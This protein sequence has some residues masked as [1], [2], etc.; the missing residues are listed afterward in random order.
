M[1]SPYPLEEISPG[2]CVHWA[3]PVTCHGFF[4][5][6]SLLLE[7]FIANLFS[8]F[9][10]FIYK[11]VRLLL[12]LL[13]IFILI[14]FLASRA[15]FDFQKIYP[16]IFQIGVVFNW[17]VQLNLYH[18]TI[19]APLHRTWTR[20]I[21]VRLIWDCFWIFFINSILCSIEITGHNGY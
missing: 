18:W 9:E 4:N 12:H 17:L 8:F 2:Y 14:L 3:S 10:G 20:R 1:T 6:A 11:P 16:I 19:E 5:C 21:K 13:K 7:N 15:G